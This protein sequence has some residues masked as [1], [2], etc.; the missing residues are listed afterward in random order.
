MTAFLAATVML[1]CL[2]LL[3]RQLDEFPRSRE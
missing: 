1:E 2:F 3:C